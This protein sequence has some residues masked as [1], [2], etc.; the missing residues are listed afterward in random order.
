MASFQ[1]VYTMAETLRYVVT[2]RKVET[3]WNHPIYELF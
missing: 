3:L 2:C 1:I